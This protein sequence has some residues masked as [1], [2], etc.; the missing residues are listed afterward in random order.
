MLGVTRSE[1]TTNPTLKPN[2]Q[3]LLQKVKKDINIFFVLNRTLR[4]ILLISPKGYC[5]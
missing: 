2:L 5:Q 3:Q 4:D 1:K